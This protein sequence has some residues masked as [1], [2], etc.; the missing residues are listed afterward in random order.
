MTM[1][2]ARKWA[3]EW[4]VGVL[5]GFLD[6]DSVQLDEDGIVRPQYEIDLREAALRE[7]IARMLR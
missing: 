4:S 3:K 2:D 1:R 7:V 6:C 5:S